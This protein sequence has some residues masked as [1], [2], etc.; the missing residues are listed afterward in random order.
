MKTM[1]D[2]EAIKWFEV[3]INNHTGYIAEVYEQ[4]LSALRER[5]SMRRGCLGCKHNGK[6]HNVCPCCDCSRIETDYYEAK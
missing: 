5:E 4:A 1:T 6:S 3:C 2:I